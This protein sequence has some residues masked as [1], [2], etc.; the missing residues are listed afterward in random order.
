MKGIRQATITLFVTLLF[1]LLVSLSVIAQSPTIVI[2]EVMYNPVG[3]EPDGEWVELYVA[4]APGDMAGWTLQDTAATTYTFLS[5]LP[6]VGDYI[7][8]HTG[9]GTDT[10]VGNIHNLY[11]GRGT[12]VWNNPGDEI[13]LSDASGI[14]VDYVAYGNATGT[15]SGSLA[16]GG[17]NPSTSEEGYSIALKDNGVDTDTGDDWEQAGTFATRGSASMGMDNTAPSEV[18]VDD[19]Y[20]AS[21]SGGH[22]WGVDAFSVIQDGIIAVANA[23]TVNI[24]NGVYT[25]ALSI[26]TK[27]VTL[28]GESE[29]GVMV[30]TSVATDYGLYAT[31]NLTTTIRNLTLKNAPS[32]GIKIEGNNARAII[33]NVTTQHN[34]RSGIDLNGLA[35]VTVTNVTVLNNG[36]SSIGGVGLALTDSSNATINGLTTNGNAWGGVAV[37]VDGTWYPPPGSDN[38]IFTGTNTF[39]EAVALTLEATLPVTLSTI[40]DLTLPAELLYSVQMLGR[41]TVRIDY[42]IDLTNALTT[43]VAGNTA[44][45]TQAAYIRAL[46]PTNYQIAQGNAKLSTGDFYVGTGMSIQTAETAATDGDTIHVLDGTFVEQV[47][48]NKSVRLLGNGAGNTIIQSPD[49][50]A[51]CFHTSYDAHPI[52]CINNTDDALIDGITVDGA[53]K[54]N[55]NYK[56]MGVAFRN[57]GGTIQNSVIQRIENTPFSGVQHGVGLYSYNDDGVTRAITVTNNTFT[58]FQ[59]NAMALAASVTTTLNISVTGNQISGKGATLV[60]AQNGIQTYGDLISGVISGNTV[61]GI[62]YDGGYWVASSILNIYSELTIEN[63]TITHAQMGIYNWDGSASISS[64]TVS[65]EKIGDYSYGIVATDPPDAPPSPFDAVLSSV[66]GGNVTTPRMQMLETTADF[67]PTIDVT[68]TGNTLFASGVDTYTF[69][70]EADAGYGVNYLNLTVNNNQISGFDE[71]LVL[72]E[73]EAY[74]E[75]GFAVVAVTNNTLTNNNV[76]I[77]SYGNTGETTITGNTLTAN[78]DGLVITGTTALTLTDNLIYANSNNGVTVSDGLSAAG[79]TATGNQICDNGAL[80]IENQYYTATLTATGN[81]WGAVDGPGPVA[82]GH[83]DEVSTGV[84]YSAFITTAPTTGPCQTADVTITKVTEPATGE[85]GFTFGGD[86]GAFSLDDGG[87]QLFQLTPGSYTVTET[88]KSGWELTGV[89]CTT[90][91]NPLA[92]GVSLSLARGDDVTCTFTNDPLP[93]IT[94]SKTAVAQTLPEPGGTM[95]FTVRITNTTA[96]SV[97]LSGLTDDVY[98]DLN[99]QG[100][101]ATGTTIAGFGTTECTFSGTVSGNAGDTLTDTVSA[102]VTDGE[103]NTATATDSASVT[104]TDVLPTISVT[105]SVTPTVLPVG[106]GVVTVTVSVENTSVEP[107]YLVSLYDDNLYRTLDG[108]LDGVGSCAVGVWI[109]MDGSYDCTFTQTVSGSA[110]DVRNDKITASAIDDENNIVTADS[111]AGATV[112]TPPAFTSTPPLTATVGVPYSYTVTVTDADGNSIAITAPTLPAWLTFTD[113]G[114]GTATLSGTPADGDVGVG[115]VTLSATDGMDATLQ[116][117]D[118]TTSPANILIYLP[119]V[120]K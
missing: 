118:I 72:Y 120:M 62:G 98:G 97:T 90:T 112:N 7:I 2:N 39:S 52:I 116:Q 9:T 66:S 117:F 80:G 38:V 69:G 60:T 88:A 76:G 67:T 109:A 4:S 26:S 65:V 79:V 82:A 61:S 115:S 30:D 77:D 63:N 51:T 31:G 11:W 58:D 24:A 45:G 84:D 29:T 101:C 106:G 8:V 18:W 99:G 114:D 16:W 100:T 44:S 74:T 19:D 105:K 108:N 46:M 96:E 55:A 40:T 3:S 43:S 86:L 119:L 83:G 23:G 104:L 94:V 10:T 70:L 103:N 5:L 71:G 93:A 47:N 37:Y 36:V 15:I 87:S 17:T 102:T 75:P 57:A 13:L 56:F 41:E 34:G 107:V 1:L 111:T 54:G 81:W 48:I 91:N 42:T 73:T 53:G 85:T 49:T 110:G 12:G 22:T 32:Y 25:E 20:S 64:N 14:G 68:I 92:D 6:N 95:T 21:N 78:T 35:A 33:E 59:K 89:S 50:V 113:N 28:T 27:S